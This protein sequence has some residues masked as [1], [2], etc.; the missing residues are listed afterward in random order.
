MLALSC[1]AG[2]GNNPPALSG[3]IRSQHSTEGQLSAHVQAFAFGLNVIPVAAHLAS[4]SL[5]VGEICDVFAHLLR[6]PV[7]RPPLITDGHCAVFRLHAEDFRWSS[8][9][10]CILRDGVKPDV[11]QVL[12]LETLPLESRSRARFAGSA[13]LGQWPR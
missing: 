2:L 4:E 7:Q 8:P 9:S 12:A 13:S 1:L 3:L 10:G 5:V 11:N 6:P